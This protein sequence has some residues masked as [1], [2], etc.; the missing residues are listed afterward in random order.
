[1]RTNFE[2][3]FWFDAGGYLCDVIDGPE[4]DVDDTGRRRDS[5]LRPNQIFALS[6]P[7]ALLTG[8][9]AKRVL[10]VCAAELWTPV[11]LRSLAPTYPRHVCRYGGGPPEPT[12]PHCPATAMTM[13]IVP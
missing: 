9:R 6:L 8:E 12:G 4:G 7:H 13:L 11:G 3:A 5:S 10:A 1:M 2:E